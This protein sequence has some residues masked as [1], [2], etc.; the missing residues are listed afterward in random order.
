MDNSFSI[1][2]YMA[3]YPNTSSSAC[4]KVSRFFDS[5]LLYDFRGEDS[6]RDRLESARSLEGSA[7]G[8]Y[9]N[10]TADGAASL[11][12]SPGRGTNVT[13]LQR[14]RSQSAAETAIS[15]ANPTAPASARPR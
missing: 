2:S 1:C 3:P 11:N 13:I 15:A 6:D 9:S 5:A 12:A 4:K 10:V 7:T 14:E 8:D